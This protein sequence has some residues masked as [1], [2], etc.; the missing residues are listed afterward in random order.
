MK[1]LIIP[2]LAFVVATGVGTYLFSTVA[3][4]KAYAYEGSH[5]QIGAVMR[6]GWQSK[7]DIFG[8]TVD[9]LT[10]LRDSGMTM[11]DIAESKGITEDAFHQK[12][13]EA[14]VARWNTRGFTDEEIQERL[15]VMNE[16]QENCDG[17]PKAGGISGQN[18]GGRFNQN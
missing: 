3:N 8:I 11:L 15:K 2:A 18:R 12:M 1:N 4:Q 13:Q 5:R 17:T 14:A 16:R 7:A 6:Q 9:E 10:K